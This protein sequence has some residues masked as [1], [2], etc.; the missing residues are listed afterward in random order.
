MNVINYKTFQPN[1]VKSNL[2]WYLLDTTIE[3][4]R[5]GGKEN[6]GNLSKVSTVS[7]SK[8]DSEIESIQL[9]EL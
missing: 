6:D 7:V 4:K 5:R 3:R 8:S 1:Q 2:I 9:V